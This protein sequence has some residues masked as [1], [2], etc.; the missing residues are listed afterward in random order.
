MIM[1][2]HTNDYVRSALVYLFVVSC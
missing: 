1:Y 2:G